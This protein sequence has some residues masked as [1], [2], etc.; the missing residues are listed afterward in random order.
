MSLDSKSQFP[1]WV[2]VVVAALTP[3]VIAFGFLVAFDILNPPISP[4]QSDPSLGQ[5]IASTNDALVLVHASAQLAILVE[6][7]GTTGNVWTGIASR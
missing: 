3:I 2:V 1:T 5:K 4:A 7:T 6:L